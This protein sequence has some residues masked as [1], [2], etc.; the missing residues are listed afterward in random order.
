MKIFVYGTLKTDGILHKQMKDAEFIKTKKLEGFVLYLSKDETYPLI[1]FTGKEKDIV[2]GEIWKINKTIKK[3]LDK[4]EEG[5]LLKKLL[6]VPI[7]TYYPTFN[8]KKDCKKIPKNKDG[9]YEFNI[10]PQY[11]RGFYKA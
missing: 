6:N 5:Y 7:M 1:Y 2:K 4:Y 8:V 9:E 3:H 11:Y 10:T